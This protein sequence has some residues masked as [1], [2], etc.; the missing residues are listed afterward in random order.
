VRFLR[1]NAAAFGTRYKEFGVWFAAQ[2]ERKGNT[3]E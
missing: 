1:S 2:S 3:G